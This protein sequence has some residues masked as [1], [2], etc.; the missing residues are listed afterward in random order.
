MEKKLLFLIVFAALPFALLAQS[1]DGRVFAQENGAAKQKESC[2]TE[3]CHTGMGKEKFVHGPVAVGECTACHRQIKKHKFE[4]IT[5]IGKLC[6]ECHEKLTTMKVVHAPVK[7]GKCSKCHD[8]HQSP[9]KFQ[10][11]AEGAFLCFN[12]HD[13]GMIGGKF[14]HGPVAVGSCST[15]HTMHQSEFPKLLL[16]KGNEVCFNCHADKADAFKNKK[17]VHA[18][19]QESC[20][21]CH[22]PH[23]GNFQYNFKADGKR[24]LCFT[25][26]SDKEKEVKEA[27]VPHKGLDTAKSCLACHDPHVSNYVKQLTMQPAELCMSCHDREYN[28][29]NGRVANMKAMLANNSI[30][31]GPIKQNDCSGCHNTHGSNNYRMLREFFPQLF[32][33]GYSQDNYKLCF[34]CHEK[35]I[36]ND[37]RTT[38]LTAFRNGDQNLHF[39]H[40]NK[41]VKGRTCRACHDAHATNN[42]RHIR[43]AVPFAKWQLPVGFT[44]T[45][46]GGKCLPGCHQLFGYDRAKP[47]VNKPL[48]TAR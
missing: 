13:K 48:T 32:Y 2:I 45:E 35:S 17:F 20:V 11:R 21:N 40:V 38:T 24:D 31:H 6:D 10:L 19:V 8:P 18:P 47:V 28:G 22:S 26:H 7:A 27:T 25:C 14:V 34:M 42:P 37:E 12:C 5:D 30:H 44:K 23:G 39:V 15:C 4:P 16:A 29:Q 36:A 46:T 1:N 41:M 9:Y 43:D 33:A 3:K